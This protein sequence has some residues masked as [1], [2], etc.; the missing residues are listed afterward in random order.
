MNNQCNI[1]NLSKID[2]RKEPQ[3]S[4]GVPFL[5]QKNWDRFFSFNLIGKIR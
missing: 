4:Q 3:E 5:I 2:R 1:N